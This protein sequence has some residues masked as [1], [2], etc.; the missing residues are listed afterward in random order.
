MGTPSGSCILLTLYKENAGVVI[1]QCISHEVGT[2]VCFVVPLP[3][4][5]ITGSAKK[6]CVNDPG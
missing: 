4:V 3:V 6:G 2:G 1:Y 5:T